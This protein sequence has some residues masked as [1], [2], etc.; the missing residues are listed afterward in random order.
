[1]GWT[2]VGVTM[3]QGILVRIQTYIIVVTMIIEGMR[4]QT[5]F[6]VVTMIND[7]LLRIQTYF[8]LS[9]QHV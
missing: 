4:I 7:V 6:R 2:I 5:Y 9:I 1:M 8:S 3:S